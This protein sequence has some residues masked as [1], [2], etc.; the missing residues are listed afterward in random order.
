MSESALQPFH[1]QYT[2]LTNAGALPG[3]EMPWLANLRDHGM[4]RFD[5]LGFPTPRVEKWKYTNL[6]A[7]ERQVFHPA[8]GY[9]ASIGVDRVPS[10]LGEQA[11]HRAVFINGRFRAELSSLGRLPDGA[12]VMSFAQ[13]L[14]ADPKLLEEHVDQIAEGQEDQHFYQLNAAF[15]QDGLVLKVDAGAKIKEPIEV[16]YLAAADAESLAFHP[17]NLIVAGKGSE[18]TVVEYH[19]GIGES[20]TLANH[21]TEVLVEPEAKLHHYKLNAETDAAFH[22]ATLHARVRESAFYDNFTLTTGGQITR[23][24]PNVKLEGSHADARLNGAYLQR[25]KQHCDNTTAIQHAVPD[26]HCREIF[27]GALEGKGR[28]VFAGRL[29]VHPDAQRTDGN[30]LSRCLLL[31]NQA[32]IDT[33]PELE[34]YADDVVCS[35]GCTAGELEKDPLFYL[36]SRG[37]PYQ[38]A[39]RIMVESFLGEVVEEIAHE[40]LRHAFQARVS[41]WLS[42]SPDAE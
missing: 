13:A 3:R 30:Q 10:L 5:K 41:D 16:V 20:Q 8:T 21:V 36:R 35:H 22:I 2:A 7:L 4:K 15:M 29:H 23:N 1:E 42:R 31:S 28:A 37:I 38:T 12:Q 14:E 11:G 39:R 32:E 9:T 17:R 24:E 34:I 19:V 6:R 18:A 40:D 26:T 33:K 25:G 27:K